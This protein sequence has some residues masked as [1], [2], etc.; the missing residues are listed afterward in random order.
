MRARGRF[1]CISVD[2]RRAFDSKPHNKILDLQRQDIKSNGKFL[3]IFQS[4]YNQLKSC[5]V[6]NNS[7][8]VLNAAWE[9][10]E[11]V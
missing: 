5:A 3:K 8:K 9:P 2:F 7:F 10:D 11:V 4:M 6:V 1:Y